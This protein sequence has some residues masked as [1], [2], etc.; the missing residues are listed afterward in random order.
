[1]EHTQLHRQGTSRHHEFVLCAER[2]CQW[3]LSAVMDMI[4]SSTNES[5]AAKGA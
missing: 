3:I 1:M 2:H 5:A 4:V